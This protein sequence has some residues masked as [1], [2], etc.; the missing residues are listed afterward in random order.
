MVVEDKADDV[1]LSEILSR[2]AKEFE[3]QVVYDYKKEV[4]NED[5]VC[6]VVSVEYGYDN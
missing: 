4:E 6:N 2:N 3:M 5:E 1:K